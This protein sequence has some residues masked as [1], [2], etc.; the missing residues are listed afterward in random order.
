MTSVNHRAIAVNSDAHPRPTAG[1]QGKFAET[2]RDQVIEEGGPSLEG[3]TSME[4]VWWY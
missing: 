1:D 2:F 4:V 3:C